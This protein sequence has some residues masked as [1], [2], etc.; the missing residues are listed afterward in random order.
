[1]GE[2]AWDSGLAAWCNK[3]LAGMTPLYNLSAITVIG[4]IHENPELLK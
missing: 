1:M 2:I 4:N 3:N